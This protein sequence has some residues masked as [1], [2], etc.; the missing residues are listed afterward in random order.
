MSALLAATGPFVG[1]PVQWYALL[2]LLILVGGGLVLMVAAALM[3]RGWP[4]GGYA[5]VTASLAGA[6]IVLSIFN[7]HDVADNGPQS[8]VGGA[9]ALDGFS[10]FITIVICTTVLL[11]SLVADDYLRREG[12]EGCE[13]YA[14]LLMSAAGGIV[15]GSAN[16][17]IVLSLG[18]ETLSI[19]LYVI[20][21]SHTK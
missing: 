3:P 4:R 16:D 17:L 8:L 13:L 7:W 1:P 11:T 6:A 21:A 2:P 5:F 19:A 14:L 10:V 15:M 12:L 9:I 20:A 18:L